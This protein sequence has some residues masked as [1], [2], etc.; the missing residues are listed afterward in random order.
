LSEK[1]FDG[2]LFLCAGDQ[3]SNCNLTKCSLHDTFSDFR[4]LKK[5]TSF[6]LHKCSAEKVVNLGNLAPILA[7][8]IV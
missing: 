5:E 1:G 4:R 2:S 6:S 3:I 7:G 8:G